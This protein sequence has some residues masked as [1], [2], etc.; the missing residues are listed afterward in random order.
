MELLD[1]LGASDPQ[2]SGRTLAAEYCQ[3]GPLGDGV[4]YSQGLEASTRKAAA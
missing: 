3:P 1:D 4:P 2:P